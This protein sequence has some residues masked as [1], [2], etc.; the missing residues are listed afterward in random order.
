M[1]VQQQ[2]S[3]VV[4]NRSVAGS[5]FPTNEREL[6][7]PVLIDGSEQKILIG[8]SLYGRA[9]ELR[10]NVHVHGPVV[11]RGDTVLNPGYHRIQLD[12]GITINGSLN[13]HYDPLQALPGLQDS[14]ESARVIIKGDIAVNQGVYLRNAI[15]F[16]SI[17]ATHCVLENS[18]VLGTCLVDEGLKVRMSSIGGYASR[19]VAF[20]GHCV[21]LHSLG[22]SLNA[23]VFVPLENTSG[24]VFEADVRYYPAIRQG[25]G[26]MNRMQQADVK[27][28]AYARLYPHTDWVRATTLANPA[29]DEEHKGQVQKWVLS[30]GGRISD[31]SKIS[32]AVNSLAQMLKCGFEFEHYAPAIRRQQLDKALAP[33]TDEER[34]ILQTVCHAA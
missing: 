24:T 25:H 4:V 27:Y 34:W 19:D 6:V 20:E 14:M 11:S 21:I 17:R 22:E 33:L 16:G 15:V 13:C 23:P 8:G 28:P 10:G 9:L 26:L 12:S 32:E 7:F 29:L 31:I 5:V 2:G 3:N 1:A 18:L 30:I